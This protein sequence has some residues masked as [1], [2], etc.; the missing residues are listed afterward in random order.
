MIK[1]AYIALGSNMGK[2]SANLDEAINALGLV[3]GVTVTA[4]SDY[5]ITE[6]WGYKDQPDFTNACCEVETSLSPEAL[7]GVCRGIEAGMGRVRAR[8][9][10][11]RVLDLDLLLY[12]GETRN[13]EELI[14]PH[15]RM[16]ERLFVLEPLN[17][18]TPDGTIFDMNIGEYLRK[19]KG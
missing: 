16:T 18:L 1:K 12:E 13:T 9:N 3:P 2:P 7:L 19:L 10:G 5:Y 8:K 14:L 11:P 6:P 17:E 15:P 4:V